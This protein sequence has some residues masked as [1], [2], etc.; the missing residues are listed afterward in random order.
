MSTPLEH[1]DISD[2][3]RLIQYP[4]GWSALAASDEDAGGLYE[5]A[6]PAIAVPLIA[7]FPDAALSENF[8]ISQFRAGLPAINGMPESYD[9][10]RVS[11]ALIEALEEIRARVGQP[12]IILSGY[13]PP[14]YNRAVGAKS[15]S[16]HVDG[17]AADICCTGL[18]TEDL[19]DICNEVI[20]QSGGVGY[21]SKSKYVHVDV[22]GQKA[23]WSGY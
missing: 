4:S 8:R 20:G 9:Y 22:R 6:D 2:G 5:C 11:P 13:R 1:E 16:T 23:R 10:V 17:L 7:A 3:E 19:R 12:L 15:D 18:T 14:D 21:Y